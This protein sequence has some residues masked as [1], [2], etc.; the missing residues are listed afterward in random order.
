MHIHLL[1]V[2]FTRLDFVMHILVA[3]VKAAGVAAH[4]HQAAA[5][6]LGHHSVGTLDA[7]CQG[8]LHLHMLTRL[9]ARQGLVRVHLGGRA[10][11]DGID[12]LQRQTFVQAG[13]DMLDAVFGGS[14][15]GFFNVSADK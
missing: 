12:F 4:G 15:L 5:L 7:V 14:V 9:Q 10:Q 2:E 3:G 6:G 11:N 1:D 8:D 13:G